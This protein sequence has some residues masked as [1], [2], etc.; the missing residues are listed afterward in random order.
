[1]A[2]VAVDDQVDRPWRVVTSRLQNPMKLLAAAPSKT[3]NRSA[4][5]GVTAEIT[6]TENLAPGDL[7][8]RVWPAGAQVVPAR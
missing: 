3:A 6:F 1:M 7:D 4:P 8:H 5:F 2:G